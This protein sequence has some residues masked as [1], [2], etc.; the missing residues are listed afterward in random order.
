M[1][2][3]G[4]V[5]SSFKVGLRIWQKC[6]PMCHMIKSF[7]LDLRS[8][9]TDRPVDESSFHGIYKYGF[10][11]FVTHVVW[12]SKSKHVD[13]FCLAF[14]KELCSKSTWKCHAVFIINHGGSHWC[15]ELLLKELL[16]PKTCVSMNFVSPIKGGKIPLG[17]SMLD[18][19][20]PGKHSGVTPGCIFPCFLPENI[21]PMHF[22]PPLPPVMSLLQKWCHLVV[23]HP[24]GTLCQ[25]L[26]Q[27]RL[28]VPK[29]QPFLYHPSPKKKTFPPI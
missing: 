13:K 6:N 24:P 27:I 8:A 16:L 25:I 28:T 10:L 20:H 15:K 2:Q 18:T 9:P 11:H 14:N 4:S 22:V 12:V 17:Y 29:T 23:G 26:K 19:G 1:Q 3:N 7:C 21:P 5:Y